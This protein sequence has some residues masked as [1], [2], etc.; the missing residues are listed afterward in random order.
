MQDSM[1][2]VDDD[3]FDPMEP[4]A[5]E[6][7]QGAE[8]SEHEEPDSLPIGDNIPDP[9]QAAAAPEQ[10]PGDAAANPPAAILRAGLRFCQGST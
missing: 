3:E 6:A 1:A 10:S 5:L 4:E 8:P 2:D 7:S 9:S